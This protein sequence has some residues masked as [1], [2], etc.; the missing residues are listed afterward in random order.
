MDR[1]AARQFNEMVLRDG[2]LRGDPSLDGGIGA[3][4]VLEPAVGI[5]DVVAEEG[6]DHVL[7][8]CRGIG[9][10]GR[11]GHRGRRAIGAGRWCMA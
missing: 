7:A 8:L 4:V 2:V 6:L 11:I 1:V 9:W 5:G 10:G 3:H